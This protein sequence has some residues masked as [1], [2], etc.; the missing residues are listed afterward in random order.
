MTI[1]Q[2]GFYATNPAYVRCSGPEEAAEIMKS[3]FK[4]DDIEDFGVVHSKRYGW[5]VFHF[6]GKTKTD[7]FWQDIILSG[8]EVEKKKSW[9]RLGL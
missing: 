9:W 3:L 5:R 1:E 4:K 2:S 8:P 6:R 7:V